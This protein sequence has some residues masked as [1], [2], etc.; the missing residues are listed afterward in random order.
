MPRSLTPGKVLGINL[1]KNKVSDPDSI[2]DFVKG[3]ASLGPY[4]DVLVVNVSSPNTP[5]LRNLQRKGMLSELLEGVVKAR[6]AL[7]GSVKP[8]VLVKVAPDLDDEQ[9]SDIAFAAQN[10][11]IDGVIVSNTTIS[12]PASAGSSPTLQETGGLS[13]PPVKALALRA[14]SALYEQTD[15]KIPLVGCGGI[16]TGQD[17]LDYAKA[18]A[19]LVQLYTGF[20]YGGVGL[21]RRIKDELAALLEKEGKAW[22][23]VIGSGRVNKAAPVPAPAAAVSDK[24][25][26]L[27]EGK[28]APAN[29]D[30]FHKGLSEAKNELE[31]LLK[32]LA[33]SRRSPPQASRPSSRRGA[34]TLARCGKGAGTSRRGPG[35]CRRVA[36]D[37]NRRRAGRAF[38]CLLGRP[39]RHVRTLVLLDPAHRLDRPR[40]QDRRAPARHPRPGRPRRKGHPRDARPGRGAGRCGLGG[41]RR[42]RQGD[43][44]GRRGGGGGAR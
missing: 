8:P 7:P 30:E 27:G 12:R 32:E 18:G 43:Q 34:C 6:D 21:P 33:A 37:R 44:E 38:P 4:A 22:K 16:S 11:G 35:A 28:K 29:E 20:V 15:G 5:G 13:G 25:D 10:S 2:D 31:S 39:L 23:D 19:S 42:G 36:P 3:V 41:C 9:V 14:L 17:A 24:A 26:G 40:A 1:G